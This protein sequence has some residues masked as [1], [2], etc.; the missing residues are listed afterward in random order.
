MNNC[1]RYKKRQQQKA[2]GLA[3]TGKY[4]AGSIPSFAGDASLFIKAHAY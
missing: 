3:S 4:V 2:N 1:N